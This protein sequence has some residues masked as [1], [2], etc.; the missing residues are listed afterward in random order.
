MKYKITAQKHLKWINI[1]EYALLINTMPVHSRVKVQL[2]SEKSM[3]TDARLK[4][5]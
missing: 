3:D 4:I 1:L 2:M 5:L